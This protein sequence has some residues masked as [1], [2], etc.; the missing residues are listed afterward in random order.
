MK[1]TPSPPSR[2]SAKSEKLASRLAHILAQL[3]QGDLLDKHQLAENFNVDVR[4][5]ERD[6]GE[7]LVGIIERGAGGQ[8]QLTHT[9]R[10]TIPTRK[11][12][13]YA[14]LAGTQNLLPDRS[15]PYLLEQLEAGPARNGLQVLPVSREDLSTHTQPFKQLQAAIEA[16]TN[17]ASP[18][19]TSRATSTPT[20][21]S[22]AAAC[23]TSAP[24]KS[25]PTPSRTSPSAASSSWT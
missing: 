21:S 11:L 17:A 12:N 24:Q 2:A 15:L 8:W 16:G 9:A 3:H 13:D 25:P 20:N 18:T 6:L 10:G 1:S 14:Q 23:G 5:I 22:S 7:R 4:T 19:A